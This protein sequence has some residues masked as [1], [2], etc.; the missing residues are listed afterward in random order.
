MTETRD[1][2]VSYVGF[3]I[4]ARKAK[5][6]VNAAATVKKGIYVFILCH[7]AQKNTVKE[8]VSMAKKHDAKIVLSKYYTVEQM[9]GKENCKTIAVLD[10]EL[11]K[12]IYNNLNEHFVIL[13]AEI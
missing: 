1:K 8:V 12:A 2:I 5:L 3:A 6:G 7:T 9:T 11:S 10:K 13:E 4:R